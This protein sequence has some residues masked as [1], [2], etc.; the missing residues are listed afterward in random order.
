MLFSVKGQT[1]LRGLIRNNDVAGV[2]AFLDNVR[3]NIDGPLEYKRKMLTQAV[4]TCEYGEHDARVA[5]SGLHFAA[6]LGRV[7]ILRLMIETNADVNGANDQGSTPLHMAADCKMH[8]AV[9]FLLNAKANPFIKNNFGRAPHEV[10]EGRSSLSSL[11]E[12][13]P[14]HQ[15]LVSTPQMMESTVCFVKQGGTPEHCSICQDNVLDGQK[16]RALPCLHKYHLQ[17]IDRWLKQSSTCPTCNLSLNP[18]RAL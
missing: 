6:L 4:T 17:C 14:C 7:E 1:A 3:R 5:Q 12:Q 16:I 11:E 13:E 9:Q 15:L 10:R 18:I 2:E 8:E